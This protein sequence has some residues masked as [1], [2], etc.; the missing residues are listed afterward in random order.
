MR[1]PR[2]ILRPFRRRPPADALGRLGERAAARALGRQGYRILARRLRLEG[3]EV[4]LLA[5][6]GE[7]LVLVEVKTT[8]MGGDVV[9]TAR[10][11]SRKRARLAAAH[12]VLARDPRWA[13]RA[14]RL[15]VVAVTVEERGLKGRRTRCEIHAGFSTRSPG[16]GA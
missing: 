8:A 15:D 5:L 14:W 11:D 16:S 10:V 12:R 4:D 2:W 13:E 1:A 9:P 7:T 6:D 3:A